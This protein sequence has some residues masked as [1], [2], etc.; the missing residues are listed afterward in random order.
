MAEAIIAILAMVFMCLKGTQATATNN[1]LIKNIRAYGN[2][3][4]GIGL[5]SGSN[6][7]AYNNLVYG[8]GI[9]AGSGGIAV[10]YGA[11]DV[12][13]YNNTIYNNVGRGISITQ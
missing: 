11:T 8:N 10:R 1:A 12:K 7:M 9:S 2:G 6:L 13:I 3:S 4:Y 5:Y